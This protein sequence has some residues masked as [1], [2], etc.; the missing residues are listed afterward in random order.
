MVA[1]VESSGYEKEMVSIDV[2]L[3]LMDMG[4][5]ECSLALAIIIHSSTTR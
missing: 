1:D 2:S 5:P 4:K 3:G